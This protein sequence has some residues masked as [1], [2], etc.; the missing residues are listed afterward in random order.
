MYVNFKYGKVALTNL[1]N[2]ACKNSHFMPFSLSEVLPE[3]FV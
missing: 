2:I 3:G 1:L